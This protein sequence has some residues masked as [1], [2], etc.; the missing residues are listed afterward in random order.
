VVHTYDDKSNVVVGKYSLYHIG[1]GNSWDIGTC[2]KCI[3]V[4]NRD[5]GDIHGANVCWEMQDDMKSKHFDTETAV[6]IDDD[7]SSA[8]SKAAQ[9][10][11]RNT[12]LV[13]NIVV[14]QGV[15]D[16]WNIYIYFIKL[17]GDDLKW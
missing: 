9:F 2:G 10:T 4:C 8:L 17:S 15:Q 6:Y 3:V 7:L 5:G 11:D 12:I 13:Q 14:S 16:E 1:H